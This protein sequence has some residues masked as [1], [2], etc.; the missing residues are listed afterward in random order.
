MNQSAELEELLDD[1]VGNNAADDIN[2]HTDDHFN[3]Y[4]GHIFT[5][6]L[7]C[8]VTMTLEVRHW[9]HYIT[10]SDFFQRGKNIR[11]IGKYL[12]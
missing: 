4:F 2:Y 6:L 3:Q 5:S 9:K 1:V 8:Q 7:K 12:L 10:A 11:T